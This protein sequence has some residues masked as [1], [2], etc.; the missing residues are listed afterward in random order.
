LGFGLTTATSTDIGKT[1]C[2]TTIK[3]TLNVDEAVTLDSSV[4]VTGKFT[5]NGEV[6]ANG[7]VDVNSSLPAHVVTFDNTDTTG[8]ASTAYMTIT[9]ARTGTYANEAAEASL[10]I[11]A[12]GTHA[13]YVSAGASAVQ[14]LSTTEATVDGKYAVVGPDASTGL[15]IQAG[16][17]AGVTNGATV[18][19]P[20]AFASAPTVSLGA[21]ES[22][23]TV[24]YPSSVTPSNFVVNGQAEKVQGWTAIG[25][26]P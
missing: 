8:T 9:D 24:P 1:A 17:G 20:V 12:S 4:T 14:A 15:M 5:G 11:A 22:T 26:R 25:A 10:S 2:M 21:Y 18:T 23:D 7:I 13:L 3:G 19:F 16:T 6:E